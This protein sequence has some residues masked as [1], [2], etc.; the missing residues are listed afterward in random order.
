MYNVQNPRVRQ[1]LEDGEHPYNYLESFITNKNP[2]F[3]NDYLMALQETDWIFSDFIKYVSPENYVED[4][5]PFIVP[6]PLNETSWEEIDSEWKNKY[7]ELKEKY[8]V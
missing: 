6:T 5:L 2:L 8:L 7:R 3:W 1:Q 4:V